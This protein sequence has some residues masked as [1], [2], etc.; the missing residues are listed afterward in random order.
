[1]GAG[2]KAINDKTAFERTDTSR[3]DGTYL[4]QLLPIGVYTV[5]VEP[6]K[7]KKGIRRGVGLTVEET[8]G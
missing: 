1:M 7:V 3:N 4:I 8:P 5:E 6:A 2:V